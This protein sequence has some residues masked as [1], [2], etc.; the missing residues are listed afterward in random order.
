M[1]LFDTIGATVDARPA[2]TGHDIG[3]PVYC[4]HRG[5]GYISDAREPRHT[6]SLL[7][8]SGLQR[9]TIE[10]ECAFSASID[11]IDNF[12]ITDMVELA[13]RHNVAP[14][15]SLTDWRRQAESAIADKRAEQAARMQAESERRATFEA[16]ARS[17]MPADAKAVIVAEL[18]EETSGAYDD[19]S[20]SRTLRTIILAWS[21]HTRDLFAE[22]RKAARH[23]PDVAY[24]ADAP[25]D[26]EHREKYSMG[27]GYYLKQ[28][29]R[30][31]DGWRIVKRSIGKTG[32]PV[33]PDAD[34]CLPPVAAA[35]APS[36]L[37]AAGD[38]PPMRIEAHTHSKKGFAMFIAIMGERVERAE[39]DRLLSAAKALGGW[40]SRPWGKTPGGFAFKDEAAAKRFVGADSDAPV[41]V[42]PANVARAGVADK[43][44]SIADGLQSA[45]NDKFRDRLANT[46]KRAKQA[47][48]ARSDGYQ[49]ERAQH[50][51]RALADCHDA[52]NVPDVLATVST[53]AA[54]VEL[55]KEEIDRSH[56]GYYDAGIATGRPYEWRDAGKNAAAAAAWAL[57]SPPDPAREKAESIKREL[58]ALQFA[59]IPGYFPTPAAIVDRMLDCVAIG[60]G[61]T[62][63]EPSAGSGSIADAVK[64]TGADVSCVEL[65]PR[66]VQ[67]LKAKGHDVRQADFMSLA[68]PESDGFDAVIMNPPFERGQDIEHVRHAFGFLKPGGQLVAIMSP[69]AFFSQTAKAIA[70][71]QWFEARGG[72]KFDLPAGAFKESGTSVATVLITI[73][74]GI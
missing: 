1:T 18:A 38:M 46:P 22:M 8:G 24:L 57:L 52:G 71:R 9:V 5:A 61:S 72:E 14:C 11:W 33:G 64:A 26:A 62:V 31:S 47:A 28:G 66:L 49:L 10:Y 6:I 48:E 45:I 60:Q 65:S 68:A 55:A 73:E 20:S 7:T 67:L 19:Y 30:D 53:K 27:A 4:R 59:S 41:A 25:A 3:K 37:P 36:A 35:A 51:A 2:L 39:Y 74:R 12:A 29:W 54:L 23:C 17:R 21:T 56:A 44:R 42:T 63:L 69:S 32:F 16:D 43:L 40:Y 70:F 34:W 58:E 15:P 13:A 50:I